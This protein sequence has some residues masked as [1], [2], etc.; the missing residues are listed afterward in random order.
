MTGAIFAQASAPGRAGVAV[1]R[2]SGTSAFDVARSL[3]GQL[4]E[5]RVAGLRKLRDGGGD[6]IDEC[7]VLRFTGPRSFTGENVVE[8]HLHGGPAV[9]ACVLDLLGR[10]PDA[11]L[12]EP[13]EFTRQALLNGKLDL[14]QAE[15]LG[16]LLAAETEAQRRQANRLLSGQASEQA[17]RWRADLIRA[18]AFIEAAIDFVDDDVPA[19]VLDKLVDELKDLEQDLRRA[20]AGAAFAEQVREGF[21]V[22]LV[23]APN[24]GKSTLLNRLARRDVAITSTRAG[25]TRDVIEVRMVLDGLPVTLLDMAGLRDTDDEIEG[26]GVERARARAAAADVRVFL[27]EQESDLGAL[28][29]KWSGGDI[30]AWAKGDL[31]PRETGLAISGTTGMGIEVLLRALTDELGQRARLASGFSHRRQAEAIEQAADAVSQAREMVARERPEVAAA[32]LTRAT[33]SLD[34][35]LGKVDVEA[36]LDAVFR[37]FCLGK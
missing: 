13:G 28:G 22:A 8:F 35:L 18:R 33:R 17:E 30:V 7:L 27:V 5:E 36:I 26:I 10:R 31:R 6:V 23:G 24:V 4:P 14:A 11:R 9:C 32:E 16:D 12:A 37:N 29:V 20:L 15:G 3:V 34:F 1:I 21:E 2:I 25:T 19:D